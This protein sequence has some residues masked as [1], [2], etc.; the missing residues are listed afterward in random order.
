MFIFDLEEKKIIDLD[1]ETTLTEMLEK[2]TKSEFLCNYSS[3]IICRLLIRFGI[4]AK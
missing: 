4:S 3:N 1:K 2:L